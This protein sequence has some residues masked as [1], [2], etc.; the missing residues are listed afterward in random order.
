MEQGEAVA[1]PVPLPVAVAEAV[2]A[3]LL[4]PE[5]LLLPV[6][7][8]LAPLLRVA[9]GEEEAELCC[10]WLLLLLEGLVLPEGVPV[11]LLLPVPVT[12]AEREEDRLPLGLPEGLTEA[13]AQ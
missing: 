4:L 13:L 11:L 12:V 1:L 6:L 8:G 10:S 2:G 7:E 3:L 5:L 9:V